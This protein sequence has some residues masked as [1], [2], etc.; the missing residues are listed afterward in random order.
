MPNDNYVT[1]YVRNCAFDEGISQMQLKEWSRN[2]NGDLL[3]YNSKHLKK[4]DSQLDRLE[5]NID[6][7]KRANQN[8]RQTNEL[9]TN[10][11]DNLTSILEN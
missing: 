3:Y 5:G 4:G 8:I 6:A 10:K 1:K 9:L 2:L 7:L 11:I